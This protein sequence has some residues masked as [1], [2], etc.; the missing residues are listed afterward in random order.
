LSSFLIASLNDLEVKFDQIVMWVCDSAELNVAAINSPIMEALFPDA[1]V[2]GCMV[3]T[4]THCPE[5]MLDKCPVLKEFWTLLMEML[6]FSTKAEDSYRQ[7]VGVPSPSYSRTRFL[8]MYDALRAAFE[9]ILRI[10]RWIEVTQQYFKDSV[11]MLKLGKLTIG[12]DDYIQVLRFEFTLLLGIGS[13]FRGPTY[14]A[15]GS[16]STSFFIYD[17][18]K[19][20][21]QQLVFHG[22]DMSFGDISEF[23]DLDP[24]LFQVSTML[25]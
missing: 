9:S 1:L 3:H 8:G 19:D 15:E 20:I 22:K 11:T 10:L 17:L 12:N 23:T 21:N 7:H 2:C 24:S 14:E 5:S 25:I 13:V 18:V 6:R 16:Y 4:L